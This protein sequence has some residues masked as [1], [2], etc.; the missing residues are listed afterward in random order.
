M[1]VD[2]DATERSHGVPRAQTGRLGELVIANENIL[3]V[4]EYEEESIN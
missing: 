3:W 1:Y 2:D 4:P